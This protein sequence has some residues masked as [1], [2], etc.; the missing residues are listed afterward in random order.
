MS[1]EG[2]M[3]ILRHQ[4]MFKAC[5]TTLRLVPLEEITRS[6]ALRKLEIKMGF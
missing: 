3:F 4:I 1:G 2:E 6:L 5:V